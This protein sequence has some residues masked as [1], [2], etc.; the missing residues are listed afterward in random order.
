MLYGCNSIQYG[1]GI[2]RFQRPFRGAGR[3]GIEPKYTEPSRLGST[4]S[5]L[6]LVRGGSS[7]RFAG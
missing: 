6:I 5:L 4:F 3:A 1:G 7:L 2:E